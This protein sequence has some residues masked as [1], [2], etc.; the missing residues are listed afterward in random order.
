M[1]KRGLRC[2]AGDELT[3][4][5]SEGVLHLQQVVSPDFLSALRHHIA[6]WS[7]LLAENEGLTAIAVSSE[8]SAF[9]ANVLLMRE[10]CPPLASRFYDAVKK[11]PEVV[12]WCS[13]AE[14][15]SWAKQLLQTEEVGF[16]ARGWGM[17]IDY[18]SDN[19]H[20]TQLHQEFVSQLCSPR[21]VVM[22]TPLR[23]VTAD[24]GPVIYYPRSH[25]DGLF[26]IH[27][28]GRD[29]RS[30]VI[31]R[32][33]EVRSAFV[34]LQPEVKAG[35][36]LVIDFLALHESG[37]NASNFP[38][39]SMTSR[40]FDATDPVAVDMQWR[41]GIQEGNVISDFAAETARLLVR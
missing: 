30:Q 15:V 2:L 35:D 12:Q 23:D 13:S 20:K 8:Q 38:R 4:F 17:R 27:A 39:W 37:V 24:M 29:S 22:W 11:I 25:K 41:G 19:V 33:E 7:A 34:A 36:V 31:D 14:L 18:P 28:D 6:R 40:L 16:A 32:E 1:F 10:K 3:Q 21:G 5:R 26:P 9:D